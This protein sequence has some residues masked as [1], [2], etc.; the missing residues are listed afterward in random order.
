MDRPIDVTPA[1][2]FSSEE[3]DERKAWLEFDSDD[4]ERIEAFAEV[5]TAYVDEFVEQ[6]YE[7]FFEFDEVRRYFTDPA[8]LEYVKSRQR[9]YFLRLTQGSY[10]DDYVQSR[11]RVG[12][13]H[14][15]LDLNVKWWLGAYNFYMDRLGRRI[16]EA[17]GNDW[18]RGLEAFFSLKKLLFFDIGIAVET[19][20]ERREAIIREQ[21]ASILELSTPVLQVR[22]RI[23]IV[24]V[25]G[26][27][28]DARAQHLT[29]Q[30]LHEVRARRARVVVMDVTGIPTMD[31][32]V[33]NHL[34]QTVEAC[35]LVGTTVL[36][37][38]IS[39]EVAQMLV[40]LGG[41][42]ADFETFGD[43]QSGLEEAERR[44]ASGRRTREG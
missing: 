1:V 22:D 37:T 9:E 16:M 33:A 40:R 43:L 11:L 28:D 38:G 24:P 39:G 31:T 15:A 35:R 29:R 26:M 20:I 30:L 4:A 42:L 41:D 13:V 17:A 36:T 27:V 44:L 23:L 32:H 12:S 7:H 21:A 5:S 8:T 34:L 25:V 3:I 6:L 14:E 19:Y 18:A 10:E 2:R